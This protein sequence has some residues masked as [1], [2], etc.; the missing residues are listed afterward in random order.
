MLH[1][2]AWRDF[3][4]CRS[5]HWFRGF[6]RY[7]WQAA[8]GLAHLPVAL[9]E[10]VCDRIDTVVSLARIFFPLFLVLALFVIDLLRAAFER[11]PRL[12]ETQIFEQF[13]R[14]LVQER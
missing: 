13:V 8:R 11:K 12:T 1:V 10:E 5:C 2:G 4:R 3:I 7:I 6:I 9:L 14:H